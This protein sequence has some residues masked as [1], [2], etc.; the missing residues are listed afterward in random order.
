MERFGDVRRRHST[1]GREQRGWGA[2]LFDADIGLLFLRAVWVLK[3]NGKEPEAPISRNAAGEANSAPNSAG[4]GSV[5]G[6]QEESRG[7]T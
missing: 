4:E 3:A 1:V 7:R 5:E 6:K 2:T